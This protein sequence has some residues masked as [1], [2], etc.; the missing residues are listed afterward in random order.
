MVIVSLYYESGV[1]KDTFI[2]LYAE[3]ADRYF[4]KVK[5]AVEEKK[6]L[7]SIKEALRK[8]RFRYLPDGV[9]AEDVHGQKDAWTFG[10]FLAGLLLSVKS[11]PV[12][13][14]LK[15][16]LVNETYQWLKNKNVLSALLLINTD[17]TSDRNT[18]LIR[19]FYEDEPVT[20]CVPLPVAPILDAKSSFPSFESKQEIQE[21][22]LSNK[23][24]GALC[25]TW[26]FNHAKGAA[27]VSYLENGKLYIKSPA[28]FILY[29][30]ESKT[31]WKN[32]QRG[33][34]KSGVH[35]SNPENGTPFVK[36]KGFNMML[37]P[38]SRVL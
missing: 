15:K 14:I 31:S 34:I 2:K 21:K 11:I 7:P 6:V 13:I 4:T 12:E 37:I 30:K 20:V 9:E 10:V 28:A 33:V 38:T 16:I 32:V 23:Q 35:E 24:M 29:G 3:T 5:G 17:S 8:R 1:S 22:E 27:Q 18:I 36:V 25:I 26:L 19:S